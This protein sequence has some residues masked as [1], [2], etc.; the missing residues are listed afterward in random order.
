[1]RLVRSWGQ[2]NAYYT[3]SSNRNDDDNERDSGGVA[4]ANPYDVSGEYYYSRLDRRHQ[5]VANPV[6]FLP[7]GIETSSAI[8]LQSGTPIN[9][10]AGTDANGDSVANDRP[11]FELG[12]EMPRNRFRN[13]SLYNV[14]ARV[15]KAIK[16]GEVRR[17]TLSAE[18]FNLFNLA[19]IQ[20]AFPGTNQTSGPLATYCSP[21]GSQT[22]GTAGP[23]NVNFLQIR[24]QT[25]TSPVFGQINLDTRPGSGVFQMQ[26]GARFNF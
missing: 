22:C 18:F 13:R 8:R 6:F 1:M 10:Y 7:W 11:L 25:P 23:T 26:L 15:Q 4:F 12:R 24:Q 17:L 21:T 3:L 9:A 16:F 2:L 20:F 14:D 5:F 19:N